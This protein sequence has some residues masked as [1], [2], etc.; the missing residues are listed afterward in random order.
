MGNMINYLS[1]PFSK[2]HSITCIDML[3]LS[4]LS[5][6]NFEKVISDKKFY[7][8]S[9]FIPYID[10]I[11]KD[12]LY[13][14]KNKELFKK[15][16]ITDWFSDIE[17]GE[18]EYKLTKDIQYFVATFQIKGEYC[19]IFRGTDL[20]L[21]GWKEDFNMAIYD[22]IPSHEFALK[23]TTSIM[24]KYDGN[25]YIA[26]HSKGGNISLYV[27][28]FLP[29]HLQDR[30]LYIY[31]FDGPGF[32]KN[33]FIEEGYNNIKNR[34]IKYIPQDDIVG[35]L[36]NHS[37][38][39]QVIKSKSIGIFQHD[40]YSWEIEGNVFN[41]M[42]KSSFISKVFDK[43]IYNWLTSMSDEEKIN[44]FLIIEKIFEESGIED[45]NQFRNQKFKTIKN[46]VNSFMKMSVNDATLIA[47]ML[48]RFT[49]CI[50][51]K[52]KE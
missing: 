28:V 15:L 3:I 30:I 49:K 23:Y 31:D 22:Q 24:E 40:L 13:A 19:I 52:N 4:Q 6:I 46:F 7:K 10:D 8:L 17:I 12:T 11:C 5:Y 14:K 27:G 21:A 35:V 47:K 18:I 25:F 43:S 32:K 39:F 37:S 44:L 33:I 1:T 51:T 48:F 34:I 29:K 38:E 45:F 9:Y 50:F 26:G 36:L 20:S 2:N 41:L 42:S 16:L